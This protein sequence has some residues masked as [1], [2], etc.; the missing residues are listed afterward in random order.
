MTKIIKLTSELVGFLK[1]KSENYLVW[2]DF[3]VLHSDFQGFVDLE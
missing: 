2:K 1:W 3:K